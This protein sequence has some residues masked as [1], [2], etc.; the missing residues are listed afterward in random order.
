MSDDQPDLLGGDIPAGIARHIP[1]HVLRD[2]TLWPKALVELYSNAKYEL[3]QIGYKDEE[4][5]KISATILTAL[6]FLS[7]GRGFYL[8]TGERLKTAI[9]DRQLYDKFNGNNIES[10]RQHYKLTQKQVYEIIA[11]QRALDKARRQ[12]QLFA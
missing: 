10:L 4:A 2:K 3:E 9:R 12:P 1:E 7:G 8:P 5:E 6:A 11:K